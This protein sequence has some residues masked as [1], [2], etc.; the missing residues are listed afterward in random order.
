MCA[1]MCLGMPV[2]QAIVICTIMSEMME[3]SIALNPPMTQDESQAAG[4]RMMVLAFFRHLKFTILNSS[5]L[6]L[7]VELLRTSQT[8]GDRILCF[9]VH[10]GGGVTRSVLLHQ[11]S[12]R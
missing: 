7:L 8:A 2:R 6:V 4:P 11:L 1:D 10:T 12:V 5:L 9:V 3:M